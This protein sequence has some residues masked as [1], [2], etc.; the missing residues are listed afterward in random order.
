MSRT[1]LLLTTLLASGCAA[2]T[3]EASREV[4]QVEVA[5]DLGGEEREPEAAGALG[6]RLE[7]E[8]K[9]LRAEQG[10]AGLTL[11][12]CFRLALATSERLGLRAERV[13]D[14]DMQRREAIA[15][16]L[17]QVALYGRHT[18]DSNSIALGG[19]SSFQPSERT[20]YGVRV[21]Q[22]V[23][24]PTILPRLSVL[25]ETRQIEALNLRAE[26]DQVLFDVASDFYEILSLEADLVA[27]AATAASAEES[28]RVL[29]ARA[30]LGL[31]REDSVLLAR[32]SQAEAEARRIQTA[33]ERDRAKA[34]LR[35]KLGRQT[36]PPLRDTYEVS[37]Q[38]DALPRLVDRALAQRYDLAAA[39][40]AIAEAEAQKD[41]ALSAYLPR[42]D[43]VFDHLTESEEGFN[44]QLD[45]T[46]G[47]D[48]SWT[49]FDGG[50]REARVARAASAIRARQ[51][52]L[53]ELER[54]VEVEV[55][56]A[57]LAFRS[58]DR[59][60]FS[61]QA[62]AQ[63][64]TAA[65]QVIET[66]QTNGD[67]TNLEVLDARRTREDATRNLERARLGRKLAALRIRLAAG[68]FRRAAPAAELARRAP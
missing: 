25:E 15:S 7:R 11:S 51:L 1:T 45:W 27:I 42:V 63:A 65:Y 56:E 31:T 67:A 33:A 29:E 36:L 68:D 59:A 4:R 18:K 61:F 58:L 38:P 23:F 30:E 3:A 22:A 48:L 62:R 37:S 21:R 44:R 9:A 17:P 34:R 43:L 50:G 57:A 16:V 39:R 13:F 55:E 35:S 54:S 47:I 24:D 19:G 26:R 49:V 28:V 6:E 52:A 64:A 8:A 41:Q 10:D 2:Y 12:D 46:L 40:T 53:R 32:A 66:R 5:S 60:L 20:S 14:V